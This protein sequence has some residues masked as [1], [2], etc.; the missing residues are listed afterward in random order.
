MDKDTQN[1]YGGKRINAGRKV[2]TGKFGEATSVLRVPTS[3][4]AVISD[5]L[6][7]YKRKQQKTGLDPVAQHKKTAW[8]RWASGVSIHLTWVRG[9][10]A[11]LAK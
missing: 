2:G 1:D 9:N 10:A 6:Q 7:A 11:Y 5:F 3:Q 4:K 8:S